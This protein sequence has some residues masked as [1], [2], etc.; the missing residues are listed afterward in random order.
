[1]TEYPERNALSLLTGSNDPDG[2]ALT[3]RRIGGEIITDWPHTIELTIGSISIYEDGTVIF[4]DNNRPD[5]NPNV[6]T[7]TQL[8]ELIYTLWD[9]EDETDPSTATIT[10]FGSSVPADQILLSDT[11]PIDDY[12]IGTLIGTLLANGTKPHVF[13]VVDN[14]GLPIALDGDSL[15]TTGALTA[16]T[17]TPTFSA[18]NASG[19]YSAQVII[20]VQQAATAIFRGQHDPSLRPGPLGGEATF[21]TESGVDLHPTGS[22]V[23]RYVDGSVSASGNGLSLVSA[24]KT[25][26]EGMAALSA[27]DTLLIEAGYYPEYVIKEYNRNVATATDRIKISRRGTG[28]VTIG[29]GDLTTGWTACVSGDAKGNPNWASMYKCTIPDD[30]GTENLTGLGPTPMPIDGA[31]LQQNGEMAYMVMTGPGYGGI[32]DN[33]FSRGDTSRYWSQGEGEAVNLTDNRVG[34]V[35][36]LTDPALFGTST[37]AQGVLD[38]ARMCILYNPGNNYH[39]IPIASHNAATGAISATMWSSRVYSDQVALCNAVCDISAAG[40][41]G[42]TYDRGAGEYTLFFWPYDT[43]EMDNIRLSARRR[44]I[45]YGDGEH[46]TFYGIDAGDTGGENIFQGEGF[47]TRQTSFDKPGIII[48]ECS[49]RRISNNLAGANGIGMIDTSDLTLRNNTVEKIQDGVGIYLNETS[50]DA[51]YNSVDRCGGTG[52]KTYAVSEQIISYNRISNIRSAHGNGMSIY[53][54]C[55]KVLLWGNIIDTKLG[56][57]VTLQESTNVWQCFNIFVCPQYEPQNRGFDNNGTAVADIPR[58]AGNVIDD[59][60]LTVMN[61]SYVLWGG[62]SLGDEGNGCLY[63]NSTAMTHHVVNNVMSSKFIRRHS[64]GTFLSSNNTTPISYHAPPDTTV[65]WTAIEGQTDFVTSGSAQRLYDVHTLVIMVNGVSVPYTLT[66]YVPGSNDATVTLNTPATQGDVVVAT[67]TGT[68]YYSNVGTIDNN[69][70][71]SDVSGTD[72]GYLTG[73]TKSTSP[74]SLWENAPSGIYNPKPGGPLDGNGANHASLL[75]TG[76]WVSGFDF[77]RDAYGQSFDWT[78]NVPIGALI[79]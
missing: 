5:L 30:W 75:P 66:Q 43:S 78:T 24:Y 70:I 72:L 6:N 50:G 67:A 22:G 58:G 68:T 16:G 28:K 52:W 18:L 64:G 54:G 31:V 32:T 57:G 51:S 17:Y 60:T 61:N 10:L 3:V 19:S 47:S 69:I 36:T 49:V 74:A 9:G 42:Y 34:D 45:N 40:Q 20:E 39:M 21:T 79:S 59:G 4:E 37:Y 53:L 73:S 48:E 27:G 35:L 29:G 7:S 13:S 76:A 26:T 38:D 44:C 77:T 63:G 56:I 65:T 14:A 15:I 46:Y 8:Q 71:V 25:V 41:W 12:I 23:Y 55:N 11:R 2:D 62:A 33:M 1:M